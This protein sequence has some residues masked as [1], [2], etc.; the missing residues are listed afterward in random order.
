MELWK[1]KVKK[2]PPSKEEWAFLHDCIERY[3]AFRIENYKGRRQPLG[4]RNQHDDEQEHEDLLARYD[5]IANSEMVTTR[6]RSGRL[7]PDHRNEE[8][9]GDSCDRCEGTGRETRGFDD[10]RCDACDG[11]WFVSERDEY[12]DGVCPGCF[13]TDGACSCFD[14]EEPYDDFW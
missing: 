10:W 8:R 9:Y 7:P 1:Q 6:R 14:D 5:Q 11:K 13:G 2:E 3:I 12:D 4:A